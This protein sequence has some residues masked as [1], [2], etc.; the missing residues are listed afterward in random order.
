MFVAIAEHCHDVGDG[1]GADGIAGMLTSAY[2]A[3]AAGLELCLSEI[4]QEHLH[5]AD[6]VGADI[7]EDGTDAVG[8]VLSPVV[9]D[10]GREDGVVD[11]WS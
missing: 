5:P 11:T 3:L 10:F 9:V 6:V 7:G 1:V 8:I 2:V 4:A